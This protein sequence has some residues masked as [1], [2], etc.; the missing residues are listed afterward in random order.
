MTKIGEKRAQ[1]PEQLRHRARADLIA[2]A[3]NLCVATVVGAARGCLL[4]R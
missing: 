3:A 1:R 2:H 4:L